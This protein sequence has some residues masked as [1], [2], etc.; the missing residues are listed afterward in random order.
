M[1]LLW[2]AWRLQNLVGDS[3]S[4]LFRF[5]PLFQKKKIIIPLNYFLNFFRFLLYCIFFIYLSI[6]TF[7]FHSSLKTL[8]QPAI[9]A[10]IP[11][12]LI[13]HTIPIESTRVNVVLPYRPAKKAFAS[14]TRRSSIVLPCRPVPTNGT[15]LIGYTHRSSTHTIYSST[16]SIVIIVRRTSPQ[17]GGMSHCYRSVSTWSY[18][19]IE[20]KIIIFY[21]F[22]KHFTLHTFLTRFQCLNPTPCCTRSN[23]MVGSCIT[24]FPQ[25]PKK[26]KTKCRPK[27]NFS[28]VLMQYLFAQS[29][30]LDT[31]TK[32]MIVS[33]ESHTDRRKGEW[34]I[35][36][37]NIPVNVVDPIYYLNS[38]S[39]SIFFLITLSDA[40]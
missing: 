22:L 28:S 8:S 29:L 40:W 34:L 13:H 21:N 16:I 9:P 18:Y 32:K 30:I 26:I 10:L 25:C 7:F 1:S 31:C 4:G 17:V 12:V 24:R 11:F 6:D 2:C 38:L 20:E 19:Q 23:F 15:K 27:L 3:L 14:I 35:I 36:T 39:S 37:W 33:L 5:G